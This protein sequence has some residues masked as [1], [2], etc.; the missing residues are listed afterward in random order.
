MGVVLGVGGLFE[1][2]VV[3]GKVGRGSWRVGSGVANILFLDS[4]VG[5]GYSYSNNSRDVLNNGDA[6]TGHYVPQL[7]QAIVR[8]QKL[9]G[10]T[11]INLKGYM[12][13]NALT[14]DFHDHF[15]IFNFMWASGLI[16]DQT[17]K[18]L[19]IICDY[20]SF[21][22]ASA[23]CERVLLVAS[24]ELGNIDPYS[25]FTP[26]CTG[27]AF[28]SRKKLLKRMW[29]V[30]KLIDYRDQEFMVDSPHKS[31]LAYHAFDEED[32]KAS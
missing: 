26:S 31:F 32:E 15:G 4:P 29:I 7:A 25:I 1:V 30:E 20:E 28:F 23:E 24:E 5:V 10:E 8:S 9:T 19:H 3:V 2:V 13:G 11:L 27:T 22:H 6:R 14:D 21:V 12:V 17:Y 18:Q 16:S